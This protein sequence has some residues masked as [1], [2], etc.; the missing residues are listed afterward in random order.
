[1]VH[2][3]SVIVTIAGQR[4][5]VTYAEDGRV[6]GVQQHIIPL[7]HASYWR[8][9]HPMSRAWRAAVDAADRKLNR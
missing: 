2:A 9:L 8:V 5:S 6:L 4:Y 7:R 1:M 3:A